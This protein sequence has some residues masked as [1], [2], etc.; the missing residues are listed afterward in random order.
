MLAL[1]SLSR[2]TLYV[3]IAWAGLCFISLSVS[4]VLIEIKEDM[5]RQEIVQPQMAAWVK[6]HPP[7][8]EVELVGPYAYPVLRS[9]G[10]PRIPGDTVDTTQSTSSARTSTR[11]RRMPQWSPEA[12][13]WF[14]EWAEAESRF[15]AQARAKRFAESRDD[16]RPIISYPSNLDRMADALL[17]TD[18]AWFVIGRAV[19]LA[20][21]VAGAV[22]PRRVARV[23]VPGP[24]SPPNER[25]LADERVWQYPWSWSAGVLAGLVVL[26]LWILTSRVKSLD[27]L[28]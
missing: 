25:L 11:P 3:G 14:A 12:E 21:G 27:R 18:S 5:E 22:A 20:Q 17:D 16:W 26:S 28:K 9:A 15:S 1:S 24:S 10:P 23:R 7:P 2:R 13:E 19:A 8:P 4:S 6:D